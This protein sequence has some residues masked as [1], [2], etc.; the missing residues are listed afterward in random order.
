MNTTNITILGTGRV[1]ST[2]AAGLVRSGH[3]VILASRAGSAGSQIADTTVTDYVTAISASQLVI[4]ATP[5][6]STLDLLSPFRDE[7]AGRI[8]LDVSNAVQRGGDRM[9]GALTYPGS[10]LAEQ[11]QDALPSTAVVKALNTMLFSVM[12][13]PGSLSSP[14]TVFV[15][16]NDADAKN[17]VRELLSSLGWADDR[18]LDLGDIRTARG[19]EA[20]MTLVPDLIRARGLTP[21]AI[22]YIG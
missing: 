8:L 19:P 5:G 2:L 12:T 18:I 21:F 13:D 4:N 3:T 15:S 1:A 6:A 20:M 14:A 10:S 22:S 11:L 9:P 17:T 7:L 16:G